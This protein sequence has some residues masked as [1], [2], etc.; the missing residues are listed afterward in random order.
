VASGVALAGAAI[1]VF[2]AAGQAPASNGHSA[3]MGISSKLR[4]TPKLTS[5]EQR[6]KVCD[7]AERRNLPLVR[8]DLPGARLLTEQQVLA[9]L[10][11]PGSV[12]GARRMTYAQA[13][14][15]FP[16]L[17]ASTVIAPSRV[18]WVLTRHFP[19]PVTYNGGFGTLGRPTAQ[20]VSSMTLIIDAATGMMTDSCMNCSYLRATASRG[21]GPREPGGGPQ[22]GS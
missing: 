11:W 22:A 12:T 20:K 1:A 2:L 21:A 17:A 6:S 3:S 9:R 16:H 7:S 19:K 5:C 14:A 8:A 13:A 10:H 15:A 18:V 4:V